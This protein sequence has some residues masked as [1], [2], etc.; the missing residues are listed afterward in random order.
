MTAPLD[1][2]SLL[3][4]AAALTATGALS[5]SVALAQAASNATVMAV[6]LRPVFGDK[7]FKPGKVVLK[8]PVVADFLVILNAVAFAPAFIVLPHA[9]TERQHSWQSR[10]PPRR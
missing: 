8:V 3:A 1:R 2:R 7:P 10:A 9:A 6:A 4:A 5:P